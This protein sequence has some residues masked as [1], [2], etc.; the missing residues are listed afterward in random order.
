MAQLA[1]DRTDVPL[2]VVLGAGASCG[3]GSDWGPMRPPLTVDLFDEAQYGSLLEAYDL[4]HQAGRFIADECAGDN[5]RSLE[6]VL[7]ALRISEHEHHR[8]MAFSIPPYLQHLLH[9]V[10]EAHFRQAIRY[11]RLI[12]RLLRLPYVCFLTLNYDVMLDRRLA[13]HHHLRD[14]EDYIS[15]DKNWS[16]IK[17]HGS[18]N[19]V[20]QRPE[21][22]DPF[23]PTNDLRVQDQELQCHL[24]TATLE[25][26]RGRSDGRHRYPALAMP[27]GPEDRL[28][29][30]SRHQWW[31]KQRLEAAPNI[32]LL[33]IGYSGLDV[34]AL[35]LIKSAKTPVRL[36]TIVNQSQETALT[37]R[38]HFTEF[39]IKS[40]WTST[41][42]G[43]F[44]EWVDAGGLDQV[45]AQFG[46]PYPD[47]Y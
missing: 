17:L 3:A 5:A 20:Y 42:N 28:V 21:P 26:I 6:Q 12:E 11:D 45:V 8:R 43:D 29:L 47:A 1:T 4:A 2:V 27:E 25:E 34:E 44:G 30:P 7:H 22:I 19:W 37:V 9:A 38:D 31:I 32:D 13:A 35:N 46:G 15:E 14:F 36:M 16:L 24:P 39:G 41:A 40:V 33:V 18:V 10:S 23:P